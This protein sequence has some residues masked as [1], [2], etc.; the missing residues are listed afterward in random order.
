MHLQAP[1][2]HNHMSTYRTEL[3]LQILPHEGAIRQFLTAA[4]FLGCWCG[5]QFA[6]AVCVMSV[7]FFWFFHTLLHP[8]HHQV[9]QSDHS[10]IHCCARRRTRLKV[11]DAGDGKRNNKWNRMG[12]SQGLRCLQLCYCRSETDKW[13][14]GRNDLQIKLKYESKLKAKNSN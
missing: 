8:L 4:F 2:F 7:D 11:R 3:H 9:K 6:G 14:R 1:C 10:F 5:T 13:D 12:L